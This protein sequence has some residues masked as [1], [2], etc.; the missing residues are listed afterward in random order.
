MKKITIAGLLV[1]CAGFSLAATPLFQLDFNT[2]DGSPSLR[3]SVSKTDWRKF[4]AKFIKDDFTPASNG[5]CVGGTDSSKGP[6]H[7]DGGGNGTVK[8]L[9]SMTLGGWIKTGQPTYTFSFIL[10]NQ[11]TEERTGFGLNVTSNDFEIT[12]CVNAKVKVTGVKVDPNTWTFVAVTYDGTKDTD[13]VNVYTATDL[14]NLTLAKTLTFDQK[15]VRES[16]KLIKLGSHTANGRYDSMR[17]YGSEKDDTGVL[18][19]D[20]IREWMRYSDT[21]NAPVILGACFPSGFS[22]AGYKNG[23]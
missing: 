5:G 1:I 10:T 15:A 16:P 21:G 12:L 13:N 3:D 11:Q 22:F 2:K 9:Q 14:N 6:Q 4:N 20:E 8:L 17:V 23:I 18:S 19:E 7:F